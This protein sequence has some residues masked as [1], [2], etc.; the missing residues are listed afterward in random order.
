MITVSQTLAASTGSS[1]TYNTS[2]VGSVIKRTYTPYI[3]CTPILEGKFMSEKVQLIH[4]QI[5][6]IHSNNSKKIRKGRDILGDLGTDEDN[7][8]MNLICC[9]EMNW[10]QVTED[11]FE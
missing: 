9:E 4:A 2:I 11:R 5:R 1:T 8:K 10:I 7:I 3:S 6:Y